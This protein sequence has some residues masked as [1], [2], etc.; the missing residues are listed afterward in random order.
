MPDASIRVICRFRPLNEAEGTKELSNEFLTEFEFPDDKNVVVKQSKTKSQPQVFSFD[1]VFHGPNVTQLEV[2]ESAAKDTIN[3]VLAGYNGTI[4]AYGQTG[5]GKSYSMSGPN[6]VSE[7]TKGIIPR[8]CDHIFDY[9]NN[10]VSNI[11]YILKCSYLEIYK[12]NIRDLLYPDSDQKLKVRETSSNGV[13][14]DGLSEHYVSSIEEIVEHLKTG[15]RYRSI[16]ATKMNTNSS[17]SHSLFILTITQRNKDGSTKEGKLNLADLAGSEKVSK[18]GAA[19]ETLE[20]AKKINQSLS[21]LGNCINA[22][23][24]PNRTHIPYRDSKLTHILRESLGGNSKTTLLVTC[25]SHLSNADETISTLKFGQ[26]AKSIKNCVFINQKRSVK[27]LEVIIKNL[28]LELSRMKTYTEFLK[29][30]ILKL[31]PEYDF[32]Q[33][34]KK[35]FGIPHEVS[36]STMA[37]TEPNTM[38]HS[39]LRTGENRTSIRINEDSFNQP[40]T[41]QTPKSAVSI[42]AMNDGSSMDQA[43][44]DPVIFGNTNSLSTPK[45]PLVHLNAIFDPMALAEAQLKI[46]MMREK[47]ELQIADLKEEI[48]QLES[49]IREFEEKLSNADGESIGLIQELKV[50]QARLEEERESSLIRES[51]LKY[52][53]NKKVTEADAKVIELS[54]QKNVLEERFAIISSSKTK[55]ESEFEALREEKS[56]L[57]KQVMTLQAETQRWRHRVNSVSGELRQKI[58]ESKESLERAQAQVAS[59]KVQINDMQEELKQKVQVI[60]NQKI[61]LHQLGEE[62]SCLKE[63]LLSLQAEKMKVLNMEL[64]LDSMNVEKKRASK[65]FLELGGI[66]LGIKSVDEVASLK[67]EIS[68]LT[69]TLKIR[70]EELKELFKKLSDQVQLTEEANESVRLLRNTLESTEQ[71]AQL[72][73]EQYEDQLQLLQTALGNER[74]NNEKIQLELNCAAR[75]LNAQE[76]HLMN[77]H[78]LVEK[79]QR[80]TQKAAITATTQLEQANVHIYNLEKLVDSLH[81]RNARLQEELNT[82]TKLFRQMRKSLQKE[83]DE[84][85]ADQAQNKENANRSTRNYAKNVARPMIGGGGKKYADSPGNFKPNTESRGFL[86]WLFHRAEMPSRNYLD[87]VTSIKGF[88]WKQSGIFRLWQ[89]HL[90]YLHDGCLYSFASKSSRVADNCFIANGYSIN[91]EEQSDSESQYKYQIHLSHPEKKSLVLCAHNLE[92]MA[93]WVDNLNQQLSKNSK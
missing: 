88:L 71:K 73:F 25:S 58:S 53:L 72:R 44:L 42:A 20:E 80:E 16:G 86:S 39:D 40:S 34:D 36:Q 30:E 49:K 79:T 12:E 45:T 5:S 87:S 93:Y 50:A 1:K 4:F 35:F 33:L 85:P 46:S 27:E 62:N 65:N 60:N 57:E 64:E 70:D 84:Q 55:L 90:F 9:I 10:D 2:Y 3:D 63:S 76:I 32:T 38:P 74:R 59:S 43:Y 7:E 28:T 14:V 29:T 11:E 51:S 69:M 78:D 17:R 19:G 77:T 83:R 26:R 67:S 23:T 81:E 47:Y 22:L 15:E 54:E 82:S 61:E 6:V 8:A 91:M 24:Q 75:Q 68:C 13:W 66:N 31:I 48:S 92:E 52:E 56:E 18:T 89:E 37:T 21:A 41:P